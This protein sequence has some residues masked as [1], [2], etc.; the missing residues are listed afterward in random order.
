MDQEY[1][2]T[3]FINIRYDIF[4]TLLHVLDKNKMHKK[5]TFHRWVVYPV[6]GVRP[7][8]VSDSPSSLVVFALLQ[9]MVLILTMSH[10]LIFTKMYTMCSIRS[11]VIF[12]KLCLKCFTGYL[13]DTLANVQHNWK[14]ELKR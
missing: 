13:A 3:Y 8:V 10:D 1:K 4:K 2:C 6:D 9:Q 11:V 14:M 7:R 12:G 5:L